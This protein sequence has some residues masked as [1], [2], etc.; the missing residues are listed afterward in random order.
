MSSGE[1][2]SKRDFYFMFLG[3]WIRFKKRADRISDQQI[4]VLEF[5]SSQWR[6][7]VTLF[8]PFRNTS[9]L[10]LNPKS[11]PPSA[12]PLSSDPSSPSPPTLSSAPTSSLPLLLPALSPADRHAKQKEERKN[13]KSPPLYSRSPSPILALLCRTQQLSLSSDSRASRSC[14]SPLRPLSPLSV[15]SSCS[16]FQNMNFTCK[17]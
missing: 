8:L 9:S 2:Q 15:V 5:S 11:H 17:T 7:P 16:L 1:L 6:R 3:R 13:P 4:F 10:S 14:R 12:P